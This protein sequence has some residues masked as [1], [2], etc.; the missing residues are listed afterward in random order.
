MFESY[1][2]DKVVHNLIFR[3]WILI[4]SCFFF[5]LAVMRF[6]LFLLLCEHRLVAKIEEEDH[7]ELY[8]VDTGG[9]K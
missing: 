9:A 2:S 8:L 7:D 6:L 3:T 5:K 1:Q 4:T